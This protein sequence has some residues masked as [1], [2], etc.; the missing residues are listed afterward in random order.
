MK[1]K[2]SSKLIREGGGEE[3]L[4]VSGATQKRFEHLLSFI[5]FHTFSEVLDVSGASLYK[6]RRCSKLFVIEVEGEE[7]LDAYAAF[8][9]RRIHHFH[10]MCVCV[11]VCVWTQNFRIGR[12][13]WVV[14][15]A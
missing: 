11:C 15:V 10:C 14:E 7:V 12:R 9:I 6:E 5:R 1:E 3:L 13:M 2:R 4:H 8:I